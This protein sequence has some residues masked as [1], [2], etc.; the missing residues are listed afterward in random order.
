VLKLLIIPM[1]KKNSRARLAVVH[2]SRSS[3]L[4]K[5]FIRACMHAASSASNEEKEE[6][7]V[8]DLC[9]LMT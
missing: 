6:R 8:I 3:S 2:K 5:T 9:A 7:K 4:D 1:T